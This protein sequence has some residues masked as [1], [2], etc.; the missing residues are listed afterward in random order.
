VLASHAGFSFYYYKV[1]AKRTAAN[2]AIAELNKAKK[3]KDYEKRS[4]K[5]REPILVYKETLRAANETILNARQVREMYAF[6]CSR[7]L[8][9]CLF[10]MFPLCCCVVEC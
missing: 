6:G 3:K 8:C 5:A 2:D 4:E 1:N 9:C 7:V 10:N